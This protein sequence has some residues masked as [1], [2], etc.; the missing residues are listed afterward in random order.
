[1]FQTL[2]L[3]ES[4][5]VQDIGGTQSG[6][7]SAGRYT[8]NGHVPGAERALQVGMR[9]TLSLPGIG[10]AAWPA[11]ARD[12]QRTNENIKLTRSQN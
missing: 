4:C 10:R 6:A 1:M 8:P 12:G 5:R 2:T 7:I 9:C 11:F 3:V